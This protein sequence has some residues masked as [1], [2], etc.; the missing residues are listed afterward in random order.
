MN[1]VTNR[2]L[3]LYSSVPNSSYQYGWK[4]ITHVDNWVERNVSLR[5]VREL[6]WV[7]AKVIDAATGA[8]GTLCYNPLAFLLN[9]LKKRSIQK[10]PWNKTAMITWS[11][12]GLAGVS[13]FFLSRKFSFH[14]LKDLN[15]KVESKGNFFERV[16]EVFYNNVNISSLIFIGA[17]GGNIYFALNKLLGDQTANIYKEHSKRIAKRDKKE[18]AKFVEQL[19]MDDNLFNSYLK[20]NS[21]EKDVLI[22]MGKHNIGYCNFKN[23]V[24]LSFK[25]IDTFSPL[26]PVFFPNIRDLNLQGNNLQVIPKA[27]ENLTNLKA[28]D[29]SWNSLKKISKEDWTIFYQVED[30]DLSGNSIEKLENPDQD[31]PKLSKLNISEIIRKNKYTEVPTDVLMNFDFSKLKNLKTLK[32]MNCSLN[33]VPQTLMALKRVESLQFDQNAITDISFLKQFE[34]LKKISLRDNKINKMKATFIPEN[35]RELNIKGNPLK[36]TD[37]ENGGLKKLKTTI[38]TES[39]F[40]SFSEQT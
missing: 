13:L 38:D 5:G 22:W 12:I 26:W 19:S 16:K 1:D 37:D 7:S 31:L 10:A 20:K 14:F 11:L 39:K 21:S 27:I 23:L 28:L 33:E 25:K 17:I 24:D 6:L 30:L 9:N 8:M 36:I 35:L 4:P 2:F 32:M 34:N 18:D 40:D 3:N 29:L 15:G